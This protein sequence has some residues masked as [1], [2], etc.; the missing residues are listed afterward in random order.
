MRNLLGAIG[1]VAI[2][3]PV[4]ALPYQEQ[5]VY[6]SSFRG[7]NYLILSGSPNTQKEFFLPETK[8]TYRYQGTDSCS[9]SKVTLP[10]VTVTDFRVNGVAKNPYTAGVRSS[11]Y[12]CDQYGYGMSGSEWYNSTTRTYYFRGSSPNQPIT[13]AWNQPAQKRANINDCGFA[14]IKLKGIPLSSSITINGQAV[15]LSSLTNAPAPPLCQSV[16][17]V[18]VPYVPQ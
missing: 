18:R 9:W 6:R 15:Q 5:T 12:N 14:Q 11:N 2:A 17:G 13:F 1:V 10:D 16:N 8:E 4:F 3:L 7:D